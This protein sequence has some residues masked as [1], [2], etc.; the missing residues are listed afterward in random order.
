[1]PPSGSSPDVA[2]DGGWVAL[3]GPGVRSGSMR[4]ASGSKAR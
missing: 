1:M 4:T 3:A 2:G